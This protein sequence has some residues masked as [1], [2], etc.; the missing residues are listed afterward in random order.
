MHPSEVRDRALIVGAVYF[1]VFRARGRG[2]NV[3][4]RHETVEAAIASATGDPRA[5][6]YAITAIGQSIMVPAGYGGENHD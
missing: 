5:I 4:E 2:A 1:T 6:V 3:R